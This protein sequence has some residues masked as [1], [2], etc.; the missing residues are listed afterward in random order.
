MTQA[1]PHVHLHPAMTIALRKKLDEAAVT[2]GMD[3]RQS[4]HHRSGAMGRADH[5]ACGELPTSM[6]AP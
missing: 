5:A 1:I 6:R 3:Q 4:E 2:R